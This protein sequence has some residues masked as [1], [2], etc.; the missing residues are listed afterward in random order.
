MEA[1][2]ALLDEQSYAP[3]VYDEA[4]GVRPQEPRPQEPTHRRIP[5][6]QSRQGVSRG[7]GDNYVQLGADD[8]E[9]ERQDQSVA[10]ANDIAMRRQQEHAAAFQRQ[11]RAEEDFA[12][13]S[14]QQTQ[15]DAEIAARLAAGQ[16]EGMAME[17]IRQQQ[18]DAEIA[19]RMQREMDISAPN[20]PIQRRKI[21]RVLVPT[22][23]KAGDSLAVSTP[24]TG[25]FE[26][27]VPTWA[28][29]GSHFDCQVTTIVEVKRPGEARSAVNTNPMRYQPPT[30]G[31]DQD[32][33]PG[34]ERAVNS[35][36]ATFFINHNDRTTHWEPPVNTENSSSSNQTQSQP[37]SNVAPTGMTEEEMIAEAIARSL[38]DSAASSGAPSQSNEEQSSILQEES[39][40]SVDT[41]PP[42][43][44]QQPD[45][46]DLDITPPP[47]QNDDSSQQESAKVVS[48]ELML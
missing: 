2:G 46:L 43:E 45:L 47:A 16:D 9:N 1:R 38:Q 26:V 40:Q 33:P 14:A 31:V 37:T 5:G 48:N 41:P 44:E 20:R 19:A 4:A 36:G 17:A 13:S 7:S 29:P 23:A 15:R 11:M 25:K 30:L 39:S 27:R 12:R 8:L 24:S 42:A 10:R 21:V 6:G 35:E 18:R 34:W 28:P 22:G 32:L 3:P